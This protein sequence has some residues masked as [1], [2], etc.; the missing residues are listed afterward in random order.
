MNVEE[1]RGR[2]RLEGRYPHVIR[3]SDMR[4]MDASK[5]DEGNRSKWKFR[6]READS[7]IVRREGKRE[8]KEGIRWFPETILVFY[9]A[10]IFHDQYSE[11]LIK[12]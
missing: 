7:K 9:T 10:L 4:W 6:T 2:G 12:T 5:E 1:Q 3:Q 11:V 8:E